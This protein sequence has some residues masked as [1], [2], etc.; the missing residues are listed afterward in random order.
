MFYFIFV[1]E[2]ELEELHHEI[3]ELKAHVESMPAES[4]HAAPAHADE[5][6][7]DETHADGTCP[8]G[9]VNIHF[10]GDAERDPS[11][12]DPDETHI[13]INL[14]VERRGF[15]QRDEHHEPGII[16]VARM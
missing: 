13:N 2:E 15:P 12:D 3:E 9:R 16:R 7:A 11:H 10:H 8:T 6:H 5:T 14:H 4:A 1:T